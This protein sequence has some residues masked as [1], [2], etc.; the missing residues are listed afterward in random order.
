MLSGGK[1]MR[2]ILLVSL[3][4][5]MLGVSAVFAQDDEPP[6]IETSAWQVTFLDENGDPEPVEDEDALPEIVVFMSLDDGATLIEV[7]SGPDIIYTLEDEG[8]YSGT[9]LIDESYEFTSTLEVVDENT[10]HVESVSVYDSREYQSS[11]IYERLEDVDAAVY[12]ESERDII[13][14]TQF[15]ECLGR[16]DT[17]VGRAWI[18]PELLVPIQLEEE[19]LIFNS[20]EFENVGGLFESV[21]TTEFGSFENVITETFNPTVDDSLDYR[22]H[23]TAGGRDDCETIY[24]STFTPFDGDFEALFERAEELADTDD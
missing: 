9:T 19:N 13:E 23:A 2:K 12:T 20:M 8:L 10:M 18:V 6:T 7:W 21:R 11:L 3:C 17:S 16:T 15:G 24:E 4:L 14:Y 5:I 1:L 22:Y